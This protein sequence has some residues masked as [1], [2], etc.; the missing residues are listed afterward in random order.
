MWLAR[1]MRRYLIG[2]TLQHGFE[3]RAALRGVSGD[4]VARRPAVQRPEGWL[5]PQRREM[6][7]NEI[8]DLA[9][10]ALHGRMI[11]VECCGQLRARVAVGHSAA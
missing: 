8:G 9:T 2:E 3:W 1:V 5:I 7:G 11:Q 10:D 4:E 6:S